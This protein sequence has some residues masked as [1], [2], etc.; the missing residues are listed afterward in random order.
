MIFPLVLTQGF[1]R[2]DLRKIILRSAG[3]KSA[4][5]LGLMLPLRDNSR[6]LLADLNS[7]SVNWGNI[8]GIELIKGEV[9]AF[10]KVKK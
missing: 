10:A 3:C 7:T 5:H 9:I 4:K 8:D 1:K 6:E 2:N